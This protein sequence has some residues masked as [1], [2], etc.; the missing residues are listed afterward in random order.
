VARDRTILMVEHNLSVVET[1]S[2]VITVLQRGS[3]L[4]HGPYAQVS[5]DPRVLEAYVGVEA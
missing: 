4:A 1:L 2:D 3:V 5:R